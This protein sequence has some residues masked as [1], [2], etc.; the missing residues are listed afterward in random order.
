[1]VVAN[2]WSVLEIYQY[3]DTYGASIVVENAAPKLVVPQFPVDRW[4]RPTSRKK[5]VDEVLPHLIHRRDE[6]LNRDPS[7]RFTKNRLARDQIIHEVATRATKSGKDVAYMV[8]PELRPVLVST[9]AKRK[10]KS[11]VEDVPDDA[12]FICVCGDEK[13]TCLPKIVPDPEPKKPAKRRRK[14]FHWT[15]G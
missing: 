3:L 5:I 12:T 10:S 15:G 4:G 2:F 8:P 6:I 14:K 13:W 1:M 11:Y 9:K 7:Y